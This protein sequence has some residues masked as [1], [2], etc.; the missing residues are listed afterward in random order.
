MTS[1]TLND[2][3]NTKRMK[4]D[5]RFNVFEFAAVVQDVEKMC[6]LI[7][8]FGLVA[9]ERICCCQFIPSIPEECRRKMI[10]QPRKKGRSRDLWQWRCPDSKCRKT[11]SYREGSFFQRSRLPIATILKISYLWFR[12]MRQTDACFDI[13][14]QKG[15]IAKQTFTDWYSFC[16]E[17]CRVKIL[18]DWENVE[19]L[20]GPGKIVEIDESAFGGVGKYG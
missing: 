19:Q 17:V 6:D 15:R 7:E 5:F 4:L 11:L 18:N 20:G 14:G 16:R 12:K 8:E 1:T 13:D 2:V 10:L 3:T 9:R